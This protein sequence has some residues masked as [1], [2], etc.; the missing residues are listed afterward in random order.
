M[1]EY[2]KRRLKDKSIQKL[3][4]FSVGC[5]INVYDLSEKEIKFLSRTFKLSE[6]NLLSGLDQD[7]VPRI[8][9]DGGI[10]IYMRALT[11]NK[12]LT[13]FLVILNEKFVLTLSK[14]KTSVVERLINRNVY[15]TQRF[16]FLLNILSELNKEFE[17]YTLEIAKSVRK[18][19]KKVGVLTEKEVNSLLQKEEALNNLIFYY[20]N[21]LIL[22]NR[23]LKNIKFYEQDKDII[24]DLIVEATEGFNTCKNTLK[25]VSNIRNY[26]MISLSNRLNKVI[27]L[28]TLITILISIPSAVSGIYGM[29]IRLPLQSNPLAFYYILVFILL[30]WVGFILYLSKKKIF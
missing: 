7:E 12:E 17:S 20:H 21:M 5:W 3:K 22:Y 30:V 11:K 28:L 19:I 18:S 27:N 1:I 24:N 8:D 4:R 6:Q 23:I 16:K 25:T 15:T 26:Y 10:Y 2:Y 13:T 29:N 14:V 9:K